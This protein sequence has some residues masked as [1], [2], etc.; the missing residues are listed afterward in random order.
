MVPEDCDNCFNDIKKSFDKLANVHKNSIVKMDYEHKQSIE[1]R[2]KDSE[3]FFKGLNEKYD[4]YLSRKEK[5]ENRNWNIQVLILGAFATVIV[6]L[7]QR[8]DNVQVAVKT[9]AE[10]S[11]VPTKNEL[12]R[13][14]DLGDNYR[15]KIYVRKEN[16]NADTS[17]YFLFKSEIYEN[18]LRSGYI[19]TK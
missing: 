17:S 3:I 4:E 12:R 9:K 15:D 2:E 14:I 10:R 18:T 5:R 8:Q 16:P 11:E 7:W 1:K 19:S 13:I 6:Y